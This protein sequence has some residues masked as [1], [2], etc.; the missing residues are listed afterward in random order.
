MLIREAVERDI[1]QI[2]ELCQLHA[3]YE[4]SSYSKVE[5][6]EKLFS[7]LFKEKN[8]IKCVV[9]E[10]ERQLHGYATFIKQFST[11]DADWYLY[12]DCL[13]LREETRGK[14]IG[15]EMMSLIKAYAKKEGCINIQWQTPDFNQDAIRFYKKIGAESKKKERFFWD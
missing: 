4:K 10:E 14:G 12:L 8:G 15:K 5:K 6:Q 9:I 2:I 1:D 11:W 13:F 7:S 3:E